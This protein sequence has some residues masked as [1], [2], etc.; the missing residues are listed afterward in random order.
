MSKYTWFM[1]IF[2]A[3]HV[4]INRYQ[5]KMPLYASMHRSIFTVAAYF[6]VGYQWQKLITMKNMGMYKQSID[7]AGRHSVRF[8]N[9]YCRVCLRGQTDRNSAI[10]GHFREVG[11]SKDGPL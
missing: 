11:A 4:A 9:I 3:G 2:G 6:W 5:M 8:L 1:G 7:F 10:F